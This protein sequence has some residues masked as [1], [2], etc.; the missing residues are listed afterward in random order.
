M[1]DLRTR[2]VGPWTMNSYAFVCP[3]TKESVLIDPGADP[4]RLLEMLGD[5]TP[6]AILVTHTHP[7]HV[8][9]L[10]EMRARLAVPVYAH[11]GP[12]TNPRTWP[13]DPDHPLHDGDTVRVG[14]HTLHVIYTPGHTDDM[15]CFIPQN[16]NRAIVGDTIFESGPGKTWSTEDFRITLHTLRSIVLA[17]P[18]DTI[19]YPG[20]GPAFRLGDKRA[21]IEAF[22]RK[23]HGDFFGDAEWGV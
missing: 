1:L 17:W 16:D 13:L 8:G 6:V 2:Q 10:E 5:S 9:A 14:H 20:H 4:E 15:L 7:D 22:L 12:R 11:P 21:A 19:C 18:D 3:E 23:D